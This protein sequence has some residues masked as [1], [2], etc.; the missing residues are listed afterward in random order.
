MVRFSIKVSKV[1][2]IRAGR[3]YFSMLKLYV[4]PMATRS[5]VIMIDHSDQLI[6]LSA[7]PITE[8][9]RKQNS[10]DARKKLSKICHNCTFAAPLYTNVCT[11][12]MSHVGVVSGRVYKF[13]SPESFDFGCFGH[14]FG[15][16]KRQKRL[17]QVIS[18]RFMSKNLI[19]TLQHVELSYTAHF[20][21]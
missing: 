21:K 13:P 2:Q 10:S 19:Q 6:V 12:V 14:F 8:E 17:L 9:Q 1:D 16:N 5:A 3:L 11:H 7:S 4:L 15:S 20:Q 18:K